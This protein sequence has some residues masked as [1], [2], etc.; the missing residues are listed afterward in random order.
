[1]YAILPVS[2]LPEN[3]EFCWLC[4]DRSY[5]SFP[6]LQAI[7]YTF[8]IPTPSITNNLLS[9]LISPLIIFNPG[10]PLYCW[11]C[12][13]CSPVNGGYSISFTST[14]FK[15]LGHILLAAWIMQHELGSNILVIYTYRDCFLLPLHIDQRPAEG[16]TPCFLTQE[17]K[18]IEMPHTNIAD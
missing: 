9:L 13:L 2:L 7:H 14:Y 18:L 5:H 15:R 17:T 4:Y 11:N 3:A 6:F 16:S 12:S 8:W 10:W 1:M